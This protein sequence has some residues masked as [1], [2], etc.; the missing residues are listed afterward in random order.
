MSLR[1]RSG[2]GISSYILVRLNKRG[3]HL[4]TLW[5]FPIPPCTWFWRNTSVAS[6]NHYLIITFWDSIPYIPQNFTRMFISNLSEGSS[7]RFLDYSWLEWKRLDL[8][9]SPQSPVMFPEPGEQLLPW[10]KVLLLKEI[11]RSLPGE[12]RKPYE[13]KG[14]NSVYHQLGARALLWLRTSHLSQ[15]Q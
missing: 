7:S 15:T 10:L 5:Y 9:T 11:F 13:A 3:R 8:S 4:P 2:L 12:A 14:E 6:C 1:P